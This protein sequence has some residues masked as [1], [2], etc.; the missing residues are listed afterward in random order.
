MPRKASPCVIAYF[1]IPKVE[2][3]RAIVFTCL[4]P[5]FSISASYLILSEK[6][7]LIFIAGAVLII[8][9]V[10]LSQKKGTLKK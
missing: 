8:F 4:E 1:G 9:G 7:D 5:I 6:P 10:I 2:T 3:G